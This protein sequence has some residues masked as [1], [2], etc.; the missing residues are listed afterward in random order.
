MSGIAL[1]LA[2][3]GVILGF[4][5]GAGLLFRR[6]G[7]PQVMGEMVAGVLLGP[8]V[9]GA[10]APMASAALFPPASL[11]PINALSQVGL[12]LYMFLIGTHLDTRELRALGRTAIVTSNAS[13]AAPFA[14]G[15]LFALANYEAL[16]PPTVTRTAFALF[17]GAAM[18]V[19]AFPVLARI[20]DERGLF[21][22]R[23]GT[24]A[25]ACAA[26]GDVTAWA[27]LAAIVV[28]VRAEGV[29]ASPT[30]LVVG[31]ALFLS[32][33]FLVVRPLLRRLAFLDKPRGGLTHDALAFVL[34]LV[35]V[36][37]LATEAL[38]LHALFGAFLAGV[39]MPRR[40][41]LSA[42]LSDRFE[43]LAVVLFLPLFFVYTGLR[44][45]VTGTGAGSLLG[46]GAAII[47]VAV[48]GKFGGAALAAR[49]AGM[50]W[51]EA[52][53]VGALMNT[54]GL[55]ELVILNVGLDIGVITPAVFSMMVVMAVVTTLMT[56]PILSRI[57]APAV[58][59]ARGASAAAPAEIDEPNSAG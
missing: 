59:G 29:G 18:S 58:R 21:G 51:R 7:Q 53:A 48:A 31:S 9:F 16:S 20:L 26:V 15:A 11:G 5:R 2:Q 22:T 39:C 45:D 17:V 12:V 4:A 14:L 57:Y 40:P 37:A 46:Y 34:L 30:M 55:M 28:L 13:I 56:T 32:G 52:S 6:V 38:G 23:V 43:S 3:L 50:S 47:A 49:Y 33:M 36:S 1:F 10:L 27:M 41:A 42:E 24:V 35:V 19:T 44:T 8:S 25:V 54:R